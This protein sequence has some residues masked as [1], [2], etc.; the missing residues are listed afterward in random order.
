MRAEE[1]GRFQDD[2]TS[3]QRHHIKVGENYRAEVGEAPN[4]KMWERKIRRGKMSDR[5]SGEVNQSL[6]CPIFLLLILFFSP[7]FFSSLIS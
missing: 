5:K 4:R 2:L 7:T 3:L 1:A 6:A